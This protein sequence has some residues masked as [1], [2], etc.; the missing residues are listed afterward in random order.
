LQ[1]AVIPAVSRCDGF[2][3][4]QRYYALMDRRSPRR[5]VDRPAKIY[6]GSGE[7]L[8]CRVRDISQGGAKLH[9][10][11]KGWLPNTFD[12]A[13]AFAKTRH[14]VRVVWVG[15]SG[16]GVRYVDEGPVLK[17]R[18]TPRFGRR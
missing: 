10:F 14:A 13:D 11:W 2:L 8:L 15:L 4:R 18:N 9:V 6:V 7:P 12:L 16:V 3:S 1:E 17:E 5:P